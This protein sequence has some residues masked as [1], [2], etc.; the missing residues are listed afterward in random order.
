MKLKRLVLKDKPDNKFF[1]TE[2]RIRRL[3]RTHLVSLDLE[4]GALVPHIVRLVY[5]LIVNKTVE[6]LQGVLAY[7][8]GVNMPF[9]SACHSGG[10]LH[11]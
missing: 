9:S 8:A 7:I 4:Y 10:S 1:A 6:T 3:V 5:K 11:H 2:L